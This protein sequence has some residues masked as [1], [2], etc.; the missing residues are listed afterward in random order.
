MYLRGLLG[1]REQKI[2]INLPS[3]NLLCSSSVHLPVT[4]PYTCAAVQFFL[5]LR[6]FKAELFCPKAPVAALTSNGIKV[7]PAGRPCRTLWT[8]RIIW[9]RWLLSSEL[10]WEPSCFEKVDLFLGLRFGAI[11]LSSGALKCSLVRSWTFSAGRPSEASP[12]FWF[13]DRGPSIATFWPLRKES[14]FWARPASIA[15][16][17]CIM[18]V[19]SKW[20]V[21]GVGKVWLPICCYFCSW[22]WKRTEETLVTISNYS[23][24]AEKEPGRF[25]NS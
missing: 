20:F 18:L 21:L 1:I 5:F 2:W 7:W 11:R 13:S 25:F 9:C 23:F 8:S 17:V 24:L 12:L 3:W 19:A 14:D 22:N 10:S 16:W 6:I 15:F 4:L